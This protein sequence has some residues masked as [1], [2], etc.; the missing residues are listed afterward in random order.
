MGY[1]TVPW[2]SISTLFFAFLPAIFHLR[3]G[4]FS[5]FFNFQF[6]FF[7]QFLIL[8]YSFNLSSGLFEQGDE[9]TY[10]RSY[11]PIHR[12]RFARKEGGRRRGIKDL[13]FED[14]GFSCVSCDLASIWVDSIPL[15]YS[16]ALAHP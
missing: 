15:E 5:P 1:L 13:G 6:P 2:I 16:T 14:L 12:L 9:E 8:D 10:V 3:P 7:N 4:V 11:A